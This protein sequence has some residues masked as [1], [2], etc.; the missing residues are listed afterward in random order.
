MARLDHLDLVVSSVDRSL[1]FY[2]ELLRPLGR[3]WVREVEGERGETIHYLSA[4]TAA[5][6]SACAR[7][8]RRMRRPTIATRWAFITSPSTVARGG[9]SIAPP[10]GPGSTV[11]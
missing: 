8:G 2:R 11:P 7:A 9:R 4:A 3:R 5:R 10:A 1:P 6:R